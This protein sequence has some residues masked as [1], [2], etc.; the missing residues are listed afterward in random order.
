M[1]NKGKPKQQDDITNK[2]MAEKNV[3]KRSWKHLTVESVL[4]KD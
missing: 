1:S 4:E 2:K 3:S